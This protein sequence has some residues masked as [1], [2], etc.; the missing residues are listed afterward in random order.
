MSDRAWTIIGAGIGALS[1]GVSLLVPVNK[2]IGIGGIVVGVLIT[3]YG[4]V[5]DRLNSNKLSLVFSEDPPYTFRD[6]KY[7]YRVEFRL[8]VRGSRRLPRD[9]K[10]LVTN[11]QPQPNQFPYFRADYPYSLAQRDQ[12][13]ERELLFQ[14][15]A[16]WNNAEGAPIFC[17]IQ[18]DTRG[19]PD[20]FMMKLGE[21]WDVALRVHSADAGSCEAWMSVAVDA[22]GRVKV[23]RYSWKPITL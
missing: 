22:H 14:F 11:I 13:G 4:I 20:T 1:I 9:V 5:H 8:G 21:M 19:E 17:G 12:I 6:S 15:G 18:V 2:W 7:Q 3:A 10:V 16:A 23:R